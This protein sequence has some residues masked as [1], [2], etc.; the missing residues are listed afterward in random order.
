MSE[1]G[2]GAT[3]SMENELLWELDRVGGALNDL[4]QGADIGVMVGGRLARV[5]V[6]CVTYCTH[7]DVD[8][9]LRKLH[10]IEGDFAEELAFPVTGWRASW[11]NWWHSNRLQ[12]LSEAADDLLH[13]VVGHAATW[14]I[15]CHDM[16]ALTVQQ[17]KVKL[18]A[19]AL[20]AAGE[21]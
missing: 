13:L 6:Y 14:S 5:T 12:A 8:E 21:Y 15:K 9:M 20:I 10:R 3:R 17:V 19:A 7:R 18:A 11:M 4:R 16:P 1:A 2:K